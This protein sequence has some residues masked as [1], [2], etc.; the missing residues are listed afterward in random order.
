MAQTPEERKIKRLEAE[1]KKL[2]DER[3]T[4]KEHAR[5]LDNDLQHERKWRQD[6][7]RLMKAATSEDSLKDYER[8][9]W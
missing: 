2:K 4:L 6:F 1:V 7:Q 3:E 9:Y 8:R 5:Q